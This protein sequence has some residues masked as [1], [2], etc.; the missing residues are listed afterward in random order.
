MMNLNWIRLILLFVCLFEYSM[1]EALYE[2]QVSSVEDFADNLENTN[3]NKLLFNK[4]MNAL[5]ESNLETTST[6]ADN[7]PV[8]EFNRQ[9]RRISVFRNV[10]H[11]CRIQK[12]KEKNLCLY[13]ATLYQNVKGFHGL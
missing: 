1:Q 7:E 12:R 10:Y 9:R 11:Q 2:P 3:E 8:F 4:L 6:T 5:Q 13:L